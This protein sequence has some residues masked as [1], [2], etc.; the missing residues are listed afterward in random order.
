MKFIADSMLGRLAKL[1]RLLGH[2]TLYYPHIDDALLLRTAREDSRILLTRDTRLVKVRGL[3]NF[4]LIKENDP[5]KQLKVVIQA[6]NLSVTPGPDTEGAV[7]M[8]RCAVCNTLL[9]IVRKED[10]KDSV[11]EYV[12]RTSD[13]FNQCPDCARL[14]WKGT[15][16]EKFRKKLSDILNS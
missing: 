13:A 12:Y 10:I 7:P 14:Y 11:P 9:N 4:L 16:P 1:L 5:F 15:H 3:R 2:D 8:S 6:F